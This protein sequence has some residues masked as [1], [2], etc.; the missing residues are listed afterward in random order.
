ME[1]PRDD[2]P[3]IPEREP[4]RGS[5]DRPAAA[6]VPVVVRRSPKF[7]PFVG[8]GAVL[9]VLVAVISAYTG[10]GSAEFT[11][12]SVAGFLAVFFGLA[13]VLVGC[14]AYLVADRV[15]AKRATRTTAVPLDGPGAP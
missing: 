4:D 12:A 10:A 15:G 7:W 9:G 13:G 8:A 14:I 11:R 1:S 2:A 5:E 3:K 6:S